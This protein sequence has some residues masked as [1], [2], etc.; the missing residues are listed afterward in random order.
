LGRNLTPKK[1]LTHI[2][3]G[4][5]EAPQLVKISVKVSGEFL[6]GAKVV[7]CKYKCVH[8]ELSRHEGYSTFYL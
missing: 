2:N 4:S 5:L 7:F 6:K 1:Q 3:L 8:M